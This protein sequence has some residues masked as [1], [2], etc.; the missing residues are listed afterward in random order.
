MASNGRTI[1]ELET[2]YRA[3]I[4][5]LYPNLPGST[6]ENH[7]KSLRIAGVSTEIRNY[8]NRSLGC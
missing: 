2:S 3:L 8:P 6:E 4:E 1:Y 7:D 5:V